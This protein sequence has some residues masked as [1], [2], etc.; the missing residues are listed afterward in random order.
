VTNLSS[1]LAQIKNLEQVGQTIQN[2]NAQWQSVQD[3][4]NRTVAAAQEIATRMKTETDEFF[5]FLD[6]TDQQEKAALKLELQK[7]R[8][9]EED[10]LQVSVRMLDHIYALYSAGRRSGQ[11]QLTT[12]LEQ[13][14]AACRD[15]ARRVGL[16]PFVP[17]RNERY[18]PKAHQIA[19]QN[20]VVGAE[21]VVEETLATGYT[22]QGQ[23]LRRAL[24]KVATHQNLPKEQL[25][26]EQPATG[27]DDRIQE[28]AEPSEPEA[29][30]RETHPQ[31][32]LG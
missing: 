18:D 9:M 10:W 5:K 8:K 25:Q 14:Q 3:S 1:T 17:A 20:A 12:Q 31:L 13:F 23:L 4:A 6:Q 22:F 29:P 26:A 11:P 16:I 21:S 7:W 28:R 30:P 32:P 2:A 27:E 19:D 24:V 15:S